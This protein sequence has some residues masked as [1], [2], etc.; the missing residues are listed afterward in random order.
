[1]DN[2]KKSLVELFDSIIDLQKTNPDAVESF[3]LSEMEKEMKSIAG[4]DESK[5]IKLQQFQWNINKELRKYK[6]PIARMNKMAELF[7]TGVKKF[8][9]AC[10][11]KFDN[12]I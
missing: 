12:E 11:G 4:D 2:D 5:L 1:M 9:L 6:D 10:K 3:I 8:E 7:W